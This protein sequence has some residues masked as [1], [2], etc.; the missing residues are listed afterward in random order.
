[1]D[2]AQAGLQ[3][4]PFAN[5]G[6]SDAM[7]QVGGTPRLFRYSSA[8]LRAAQP[9]AI[10]A[11]QRLFIRLASLAMPSPLP[12]TQA[13]L[14][15]TRKARA[16]GTSVARAAFQAKAPEAKAAFIRRHL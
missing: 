11:G 6:R 14:E 16:A 9:H 15:A 3:V 12:S 13:A 2:Q 1:M 7:V 5:L 4:E 10:A 8:M